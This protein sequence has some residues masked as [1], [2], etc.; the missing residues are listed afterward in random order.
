M[1]VSGIVRFHGFSRKQQV[2][3][4]LADGGGAFAGIL[5]QRIIVAMD[6]LRKAV[7]LFVK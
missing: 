6:W 2:F 7:E 4:V 1:K 3:A 5:D